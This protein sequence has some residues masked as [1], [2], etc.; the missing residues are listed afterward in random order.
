[1]PSISVQTN[2][3]RNYLVPAGGDTHAVTLSGIFSATPFTQDWRNFS[4][5]NFPFTPQGVFIDNTQGTASIVV[6]IDPI[7]FSVECAAGTT[8]QFQFPAPAGI[9]CSITGG[10]QAS[11]VFVDF[12]V[13]P[14]GGA[15]TAQ[16]SGVST[17]VLVPTQPAQ[18]AT[19]G[20]PYSVEIIN[21]AG[22][23]EYLSI[24][25]GATSASVTPGTPNLNLRKLVL[26]ISENA[27]LAAAGTDLVTVTADG[28]IVFKQ[29]PYIAAAIQG[30]IGGWSAE[31]D[32]SDFNIGMSTGNLTVTLGTALATGLLECN[33]Y[34]G[35]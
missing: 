2:N 15:I 5:N 1:M 32:F 10:G 13:L 17:G 21:Q 34:F 18:S 29:S 24:A 28:V 19:G 9:T 7:G 31:I 22:V 3:T 4:V 6:T 16:I 11:L 25:A 33:A 14:N 8:G 35:V 27:T 30:G 20:V 26:S 23:A 12:P